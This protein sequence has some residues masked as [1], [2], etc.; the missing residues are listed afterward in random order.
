M[1]TGVL[2]WELIDSRAKAAAEQVPQHL[3][4]PAATL[5]LNPS[6]G[7]PTLASHRTSG[8]G[9]LWELAPTPG[10]DTRLLAL[11]ATNT[12]IDNS[13]LDPTIAS[14]SSVAPITVDP[15]APLHTASGLSWHVSEPRVS[16]LAR[17]M[18]APTSSETIPSEP[19]VTRGPVW[20]LVK[21]GEEFKSSDLAM[22]IEASEEARAKAA[23]QADAL[24]NEAINNPPSPWILGIGGG[25]RIGIGEPN[26][27][28][29][30][31]R[32]GFMLNDDLAMSVRPTYTFGNSDEFGE[33]NNEGAFKMPITLDIWPNFWISPNIG[34][35]LASNTD[36]DGKTRAMYS[37]G[38]DI[39]L[40]KNVSLALGLNYIL[41]SKDAD[42]RDAEAFSALYLR[43]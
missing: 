16:L 30:Y 20:E 13:D 2:R 31:G 29:A 36:S 19:I 22:E 41:D 4:T 42:N 11:A 24:A 37:G 25:A 9:L 3:P 8:T 33:P 32:L 1:V 5:A 38:I 27:W 14:D 18:P 34:L 28:M 35:G 17:A 23:E 43:F 12:S 40:A 10:T 6:T 26:Y 39:R 7:F 21:P 15:P